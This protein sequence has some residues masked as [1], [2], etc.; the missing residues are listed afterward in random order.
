MGR[1]SWIGLTAAGLW[2]A[3]QA[4]AYAAEEFSA[5][6]SYSF[7]GTVQSSKLAQIITG[8][9]TQGTGGASTPGGAALFVQREGTFQAGSATVVDDVMMRVAFGQ[10][11]IQIGGQAA[12]GRSSENIIDTV[13][14]LTMLSDTLT[15]TGLAPGKHVQFHEKLFLNGTNDLIAQDNTP[16]DPVSSIALSGVQVRVQGTGVDSRFNGVAIVDHEISSDSGVT[17]NRRPPAFIDQVVDL[18][19]GIATKVSVS[20]NVT[21]FLQLQ[22]NIVTPTIG[23]FDGNYFDTLGYLPGAFFT[24]ADTG[25]VLDNVHLVSASGFDYLNPPAEVAGGV[26]EPASWAL[27]ISGFGMAG[28]LLRR[29]RRLA[30][31]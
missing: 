23:T 3:V 10:M 17:S 11:G 20:L 12:M 27:M 2:L 1:A 18:F 8:G 5:L 9:E 26:P 21:G 22:N 16:H 7:S 13:D 30:P 19:M 25:E 15:V 29:R 14:A 28:G 6:A 31:V 4:P 24:D